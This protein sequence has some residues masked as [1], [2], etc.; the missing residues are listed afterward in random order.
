MPKWRHPDFQKVL[1][2]S[3]WKPRPL[4]GLQLVAQILR[5][6][7]EVVNSENNIEQRGLR[8]YWQPVADCRPDQR[9]FTCKTSTERNLTK[10]W[11]SGPSFQLSFHLY[12]S[13]IIWTILLLTLQHG[14]IPQGTCNHELRLKRTKSRKGF[15]GVKTEDRL[16][17]ILSSPTGS[18]SQPRG[19]TLKLLP[20]TGLVRC[21]SHSSSGRFIFFEKSS[22]LIEWEASQLADEGVRA[23]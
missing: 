5:F 13:P 20:W 19:R 3:A 22:H 11:G 15:A 6:L 12:Y 18:M 9:A 7:R 10:L 4:K 17:R 8:S 1:N 21:N 14:L 23:C 2:A 16:Q